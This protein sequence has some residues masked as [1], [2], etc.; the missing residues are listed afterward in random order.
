MNAMQRLN[1]LIKEKNSRICAGLDPTWENI[2]DAFKAEYGWYDE[3]GEENMA[4]FS[5]IIYKYCERY[6]DAVEDIVP[7]IKINSAF[8]EREHLEDLYLEVARYAEEKG[9]FVIGDLYRGGDRFTSQAYAEAFL[10]AGQPFDAITIVPCFGTN[11]AKPFIELAKEQG[12]G[13]FVLVKTSEESSAEIRDLKLEN[14]N[15]LFVAV[16]DLVNDWGEEVDP[17]SEKNDYN[18]VGAVVGATNPIELK[19]LSE[20]MKRT[21]LLL[22][23]Y[24]AQGATANDVATAFDE[25]GLGA[26]VNSSRGI[27]QAYKSD[28]WKDEYCEK[29]WAEAARAEAI[30]ATE[31]INDAINR[32]YDEDIC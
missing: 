16:S 21:F 3:K 31:E 29:T 9:L 13:V 15:P 22:P 11:G 10:S 19:V 20:R 32:Y 26:I 5:Q 4:D 17:W 24:G 6:I 23:G 25:E 14:G 1:E 2:P 7:A 18:M 8:F 28:R 30:R 27:M 12:K